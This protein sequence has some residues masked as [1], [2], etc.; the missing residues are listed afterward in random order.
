[1][2]PAKIRHFSKRKDFFMS[3]KLAV[4]LF[5]KHGY[6]TVRKFEIRGADANAIAV[7]AAA[8][9]ADLQAIT[10]L[11]TRKAAVLIP[12]SGEDACGDPSYTD[13]GVTIR[14]KS[15]TDGE[16]VIVK[17]PDL[18]P[19]MYDDD[20]KVILTDVSVD[21]FLDN[22]LATGVAYVSDGESVDSWLFGTLDKK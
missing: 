16:T 22:F 4:T 11:G 19:T 20:G 6:E 3:G 1:M 15:A 18:D 14:G 10:R 9:L 21:A 8:F 7:N 12:I 17:V 5:D 13:L 2:K